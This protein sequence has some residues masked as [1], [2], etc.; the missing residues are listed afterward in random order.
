MI[1][2]PNESESL[3]LDVES[4]TSFVPAPPAQLVETAGFSWR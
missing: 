1:I 2:P 3:L 4:Q